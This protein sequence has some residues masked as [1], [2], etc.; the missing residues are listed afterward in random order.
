MKQTTWGIHK[1]S[2]LQGAFLIARVEPCGKEHGQTDLKR[3]SVPWQT[4]SQE[5]E[6]ERVSHKI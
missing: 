1:T 3:D 6:I 4:D 2:I 5:L